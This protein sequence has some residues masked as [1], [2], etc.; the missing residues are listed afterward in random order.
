[1]EKAATWGCLVFGAAGAAAAYTQ[2]APLE[3]VGQYAA[4]GIAGALLLFA[5]RMVTDES[6]QLE[7]AKN[8]MIE[9]LEN[10]YARKYEKITRMEETEENFR[11]EEE[12]SVMEEEKSEENAVVFSAKEEEE[13]V[14]LEENL[15]EFAPEETE[16]GE[17][18]KGEEIESELVTLMK[19]EQEKA[20]EEEERKEKRRQDEEMIRQI[21]A[22]FLT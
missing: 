16:V 20:K 4:A 2:D 9:F 19:E 5:L 12:E 3:N 1:M 7:A 13:K 18:G 8:Y 11:T 15:M 6:Y 21:L 14:P 22:E 17:E 10:T